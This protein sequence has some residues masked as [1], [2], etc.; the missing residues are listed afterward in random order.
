MRHLRW[1]VVPSLFLL[2]AMTLGASSAAPNTESPARLPSRVRW[3]PTYDLQVPRPSG[4]AFSS[5]SGLFYL[6]GIAAD[7][8]S[9]LATATVMKDT[10]GALTMPVGLPV[11]GRVGRRGR[12]RGWARD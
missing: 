6:G 11:L 12:T 8:S 3:E 2:S 4:L 10:T 7:G 1:I 5:R 9:L